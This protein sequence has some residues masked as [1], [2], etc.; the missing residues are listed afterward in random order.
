MDVKSPGSPAWRLSAWYFAYFAFVGAYGPYFG[1]YLQSLGIDAFGIGVLLSLMQLSRLLLPLFWRWAGHR[2]DGRKAVVVR[3]S[4]G[5]GAAVFLALVWLRDFWA[6][7]A[8]MALLAFFLSAAMPMVESLTLDH[9]RHQ[10]GRYGHIRLWGSVGYIVAVQAIGATL[11]ASALSLLPW[12]CLGVLLICWGVSSTLEE[13]YSGGDAV[14]AMQWR[15]TFSDP[16]VLALLAAGFFMVLAHG[17]LYVFYSIH[18]VDHGYG[19]G[20]VGGLWALGVVVEILVFLFMPR[21]MS[22]FSL[23]R[24]MLFSFAAAVVRFLLIG[25]LV[26]QPVVVLFAQTLHGATF[27]VHHAATV[28]AL[29]RWVAPRHHAAAMALYGAVAYGAGGLLGGLVSG[30]LWTP[31]GAGVVFSL[32][33]VAALLGGMLVLGVGGLR[34][35]GKL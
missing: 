15:E 14:P 6:L 22:A 3:W 25:W 10:A 35:G 33:S 16:R 27:G 9:L 7:F 31:L 17:P 28:A 12:L 4:V 20:A 13:S 24:L 18:L 8:A 29:N 5:L 30:A 19:K 23:G 26:D 11:E 32:A 1:L 34:A 2:R 21:L